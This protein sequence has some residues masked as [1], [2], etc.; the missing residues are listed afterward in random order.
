MFKYTQKLPTIVHFYSHWN[1]IKL[2]C[3][4]DP[5]LTMLAIWIVRYIICV[6]AGGMLVDVVFT[7]KHRQ[8]VLVQAEGNL[9]YDTVTSLRE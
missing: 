9:E 4:T 2:S 1:N 8:R 3:D 7:L 5:L 6:P